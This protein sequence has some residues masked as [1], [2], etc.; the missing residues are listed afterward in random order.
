M[1][2][3]NGPDHHCKRPPKYTAHVRKN[4]FLQ[5]WNAL[6]RGTCFKKLESDTIRMLKAAWK[7][8]ANLAAI[9][10]SMNLQSQLL[11]WLLRLDTHYLCG[12]SEGLDDGLELEVIDKKQEMGDGKASEAEDDGSE[13][14]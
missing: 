11:A 8:N 3:G 9:R 6:T 10:V 7:H 4:P 12:S 1:G 5:A 2:C 14:G 13:V